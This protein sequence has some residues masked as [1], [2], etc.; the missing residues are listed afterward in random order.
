MPPK[1]TTYQKEGIDSVKNYAELIA[2]IQE[3]PLIVRQWNR[4]MDRGT[5]WILQM[6]EELST[7]EDCPEVYTILG[8]FALILNQ[9]ERAT[10][11]FDTAFHLGE[12][13]DWSDEL[14]ICVYLGQVWLKLLTNRGKDA[15]RDL[16]IA[17]KQYPNHLMLL[18]LSGIES[19]MRKD[20]FSAQK[21]FDRAIK[22]TPNNPE[23]WF[24]KGLTAVTEKKGKEATE[25][26]NECLQLDAKNSE[27]LYYLGYIALQNQK[28]AEASKFWQKGLE[29]NPNNVE[30][31]TQLGIQYY[32]EENLSNARMLLTRAIR[33][34][35][36]FQGAWFPLG[37]VA[38]ELKLYK[39][40][41]YLHTKALTFE[42]ENAEILLQRGL[43]YNALERFDEAEND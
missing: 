17:E 20:Y 43:A 4:W 36:L 8:Y 24:E 39:W 11:Y 37:K 41:V 32:E 1:K 35:P 13:S 26:F 29:L 7:E 38:Y 40:A 15:Q 5:K 12:I 10:S 42:P 27:A 23:I 3:N 25:Y 21:F 28:S 22:I 16:T 6:T 18:V 34:E 14:A 19:R 33:L 31:L 30:I 9:V 2:A